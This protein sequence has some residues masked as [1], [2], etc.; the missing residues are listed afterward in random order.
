MRPVTRS[1]CDFVEK[2][3]ALKMNR[4]TN[5]FPF[6]KFDGVNDFSGFDC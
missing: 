6:F 3:S 1:R 4:P 5:F 2:I